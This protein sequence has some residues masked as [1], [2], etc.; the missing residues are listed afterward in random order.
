MLNHQ[1]TTF[2]LCCSVAC[3]NGVP[4]TELP[5]SAARAQNTQPSEPTH[6][7]P[8]GEA[9]QD[10]C[11]SPECTESVVPEQRE[12]KFLEDMGDGWQRLLEMDW[13]IAAGAEGYRCKTFTLSEELYVT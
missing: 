11:V 5:K 2:V 13:E 6:A 1:V 8:A 10:R 4:E 9:V 12:A 3:S 7:V